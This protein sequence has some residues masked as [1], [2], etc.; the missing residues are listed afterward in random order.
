[1]QL[2]CCGVDDY[3]D[4]TNILHRGIP[5]SCCGKEVD[6]ECD[7]LNAYKKGCAVALK[8]LFTTACVGLGGVAL[9]I[10]AIEVI[11]L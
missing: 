9:G 11:S 3:R 8:D 7:Q 2:E 5:G 6:V 4:F 10:A 1:M